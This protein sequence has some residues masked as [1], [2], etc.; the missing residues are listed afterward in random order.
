MSVLGK[1]TAVF[2][3]LRK[4]VDMIY[5]RFSRKVKKQKQI[6]KQIR[7]IEKELA[8]ALRYG[9]ITDAG[10]LADQ[11]FKLYKELLNREDWVP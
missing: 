11:R 10:Y 5:S 1:F 4:I 7:K 8:E 2:G 3:V 6:E 9:K